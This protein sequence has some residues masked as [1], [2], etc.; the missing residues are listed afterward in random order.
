M[1]VLVLV[2]VIVIVIVDVS[3]DVVATSSTT[4][5]PITTASTRE[6]DRVDRAAL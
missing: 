4:T 5:R 6:P 1:L 3:G 2:L